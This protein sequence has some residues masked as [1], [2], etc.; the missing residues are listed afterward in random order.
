MVISHNVLAMNMGRQLNIAT[1]NKKKSVEKLSSGYRINKSA[2]DA[3]GLTISEKMRTQIRG[4]KRGT[5]NVQDGTSMCQVGDGALAEVN[6]MLNRI[7]ELSVKAANATCTPEDRSAIQSEINQLLREIDRIGDTTTFNDIPLFK[8]SSEILTNSSGQPIMDNDYSFDDIRIADISLSDN[9][10]NTNSGGLLALTARVD[11][12]DSYANGRNLNLIYGNGSTSSSKLN[13]KTQNG[14]FQVDLSS[15]TTTATTYDAASQTVSRDFNIVEP[16]LVIDVTVTQK[17]GTSESQNA[18]A[19][20][21]YYSVKNN[22][23]AEVTVDFLFHADTAYNNNDSKDNYYVGGT[24]LDKYTVFGDSSS[25][26]GDVASNPNVVSTVPSSMSLVDKDNALPFTEYFE[27]TDSNPNVVCV[28]Q[29][30]EIKD[31]SFYN[32]QSLDR[33][34]STDAS[35]ADL[36]FSVIWDN[37]QVSNGS[38]VDFHLTYGIKALSADTNISGD[39]EVSHNPVVQHNSQSQFWIQSSSQTNDGIFLNFGE[40]NSEVLGINRCDVTTEG[41]AG[42]TIDKVGR[43]TE[44]VLKL[45]SSIGAQQNRLEHMFANDNNILENTTAAE[46]RIRDTDMAKEMMQNSLYNILSQAGVTMMTQANQSS[47]SVLRLLQ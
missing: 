43:A 39:I 12:V 16:S 40:M 14:D 30:F 36:G 17:I 11:N 38:S 20:E 8:G 19:Y 41:G 29:Y 42:E 46:S 22:S 24:L 33:L 34:N 35:N 15:L 45:R 44:Y 47:G 31:W 9:P 2:D 28:G 4:L 7:T 18:K 10:I 21:L 13:I 1:N 3:A 27:W 6:E 32:N 37:R 25:T 23:A 26:T 5:Q